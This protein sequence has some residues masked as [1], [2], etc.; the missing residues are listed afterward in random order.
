[1]SDL[2]K[3]RLKNI[4]ISER[5]RSS[6][7]WQEYVDYLRTNSICKGPKTHTEETKNKIRESLKKYNK[8]NTNNIK[9]NISK[10][11][12]K[13]IIQLTLNE[14]EINTFISL[15]DAERKTNISHKNIGHVLKGKTKTAGGFKWKY[16]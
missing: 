9:E 3:E 2:V 16:K 10:K 7:K 4:D 6:K 13:P 1:M 11:L 12:G 8:E 15:A 14:I 5:M